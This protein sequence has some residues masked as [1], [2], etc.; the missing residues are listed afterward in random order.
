MQ[1][2]DK[3]MSLTR[4]R[5]SEL[6]DFPDDLQIDQCLGIENKL[7]VIRFNVE[8]ENGQGGVLGK[9]AVD[10]GLLISNENA[11]MILYPDLAVPL[12]I[13]ITTDE[14]RIADLLS[15]AASIES[16]NPYS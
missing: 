7:S 10:S 4:P 1:K 8:I 12:D 9:A 6:I 11:R 13:C 14:T 2:I 16:L 5:F 15:R 3:I